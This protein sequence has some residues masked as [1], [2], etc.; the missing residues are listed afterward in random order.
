MGPVFAHAATPAPSSQMAIIDIKKILNDSK[1]TKSIQEQIES[2]R[3]KIQADVTKQE[4]ALRAE[5][6]KLAEQR[7]V[8]SAEAFQEKQKTFKDKV[9][10]AQKEVQ[11]HRNALEK[12][13]NDALAQVQDVLV[14]IL[15][16]MAQKSGYKVVI[17]SAHVAYSDPS[18]DITDEVLKSLNTKLTTVKVEVK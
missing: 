3:K 6:K 15:K 12:A 1:A 8:L 17:P 16:D 7:S 13:Y 5:D 10:K 4:D 11:D 2:Q 9:L 18:I 14:D